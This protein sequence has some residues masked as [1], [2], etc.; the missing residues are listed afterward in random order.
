MN[1]VSLTVR[2]ESHGR[3][4]PDHVEKG[5]LTTGNTGQQVRGSIVGSDR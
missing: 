4:G 2:Q 1:A 5:S 3:E